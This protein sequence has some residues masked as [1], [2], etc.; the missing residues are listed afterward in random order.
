MMIMIIKTHYP[1]IKAHA[2]SAPPLH[3]SPQKFRVTFLLTVSNKSFKCIW[4]A[5]DLTVRYSLIAWLDVL[6]CPESKF[7]QII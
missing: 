7:A 4:Q 3:Y 1:T 5:D 2:I 6:V